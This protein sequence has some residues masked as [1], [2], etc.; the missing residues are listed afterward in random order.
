MLKD[1]Y[2]QLVPGAFD[3]IYQMAVGKDS[4]AYSFLTILPHEQ[5]EGKMFMSRFDTR[6][7]VNSDSE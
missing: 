6:L 4:P 7:S 3:E 5:D 1:E 2:A